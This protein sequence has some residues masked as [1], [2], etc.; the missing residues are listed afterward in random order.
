MTNKR[1]LEDFDSAEWGNI[2]LDGITEEQLHSN[3]ANRIIRAKLNAQDPEWLERNRKRSDNRWADPDK[4]A[5]ASERAKRTAQ[6]E[7]WKK[8][9]KEAR[10][11]VVKTQEYKELMTKV[12]RETAKRQD[13]LAKQRVV[14]DSEYRK[15]RLSEE[16]TGE[17]HWRFKGV[18]VATNHTDKHNDRLNLAPGES[19]RIMPAD[20]KKYGLNSSHLSKACSGKLATYAKLKWHRED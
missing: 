15:Q 13:W 2:K 16:T 3:K 8:V 20:I 10:D 7:H 18:Y 12:N 6:T 14:A 5:K 1:D 9:T 17:K 11:K 4:R 19:M